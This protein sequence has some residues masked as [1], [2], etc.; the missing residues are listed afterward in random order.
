MPNQM[1]PANRLRAKRL[2]AVKE[3]ILRGKVLITLPAGARTEARTLA[4]MVAR[5]LAKMVARTPARVL[6]RT[7]AQ[8]TRTMPQ[9]MIIR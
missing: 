8:I 7:L 9:E 2:M 6:A 3:R 1:P 5:T 4:K